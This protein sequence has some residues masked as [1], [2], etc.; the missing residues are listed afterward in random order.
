MLLKRIITLDIEWR[1]NLPSYWLGKKYR[2]LEMVGYTNSNYTGN[3]KDKKSIIEY[4]FFLV[5]VIVI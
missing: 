1:N 5:G 4:Y 2:K 3:L